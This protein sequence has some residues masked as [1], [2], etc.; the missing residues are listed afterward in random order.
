MTRVSRADP[1]RRYRDIISRFRKT[2]G[3]NVVTGPEPS[4]V[5]VAP[6]V[7]IPTPF[8]EVP[9]QALNDKGHYL[10]R[11]GSLEILKNE[12]P[13]FRSRTQNRQ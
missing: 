6:E 4:R 11:V 3:L 9:P 2:A 13:M 7:G 5:T 12:A 10:C 8:P 1:K